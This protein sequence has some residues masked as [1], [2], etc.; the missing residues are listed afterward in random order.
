[1]R[2]RP[3]RFGIDELSKNPDKNVKK[4]EKMTQKMFEDFPPGSKK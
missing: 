1:M 4:I 3:A 2:C